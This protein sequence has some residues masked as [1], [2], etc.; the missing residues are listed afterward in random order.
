MIFTANVNI[1]HGG[2]HRIAGQSHA[3]DDR[4]GIALENQTIFKSAGFTLIG[5]A[6]DVFY[7]RFF[8]G[9]KAPF[10]AGGEKSAAAALKAAGLDL[11]HDLGWFHRC[12]RPSQ[13]LITVLRNV[14]LNRFRIDGTGVFQ[15]HADLFAESRRFLIHVGAF[16]RHIQVLQTLDDAA[17]EEV[18]GDD[19]RDILQLDARIV[20]GIREQHQNHAFVIDSKTAGLNHFYL[21]G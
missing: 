14:F 9:G 17:L 13:G 2:A 6:D 5:V 1:S 18:F 11:F 10:N 15:H 12:N 19:L 7:I 4:M 21:I 20:H 8:F 16:S 3:F